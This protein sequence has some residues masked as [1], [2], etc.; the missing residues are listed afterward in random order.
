[1]LADRKWVQR[2]LGFDPI[3][4]PPPASTFAFAA[5]ASSSSVEDLQREIIDFDSEGASG[6]QFLAF[7]TATGLSRY[8][9]ITWPEGR[10]RRGRPMPIRP[11]APCRGP[12]CWSSPGPST[13][14]LR[15]AGP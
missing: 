10:P 8:T 13:T 4:S 9:E 14:A 2:N 5:A 6:L 7:T 12:M 3:D 15:E 11:A 1:M